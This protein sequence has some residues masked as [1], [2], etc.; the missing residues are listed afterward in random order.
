MS[1]HLNE[2][3]LDA[4]IIAPKLTSLLSIIGSSI[5]ISDVV[6]VY[7]GKRGRQRL[8]P[9]HRLLAG[10]SFCDLLSSPGW[11][12]TSWAVPSDYP[13]SK[14]NVGTQ[15]TC[16]LQGSLLQ[17]AAGTAFYSCSLAIY[18]FLVIRQGWSDKR[19]A[20][21]VE[22]M[23]H[24][25]SL[26]FALGSIIA[27]IALTLY[28]P[29]PYGC[30]MMTSPSGCTQSYQKQDGGVPCERGDNCFIYAF[31]LIHVPIWSIF[32]VLTTCMVL[33][34]IKIKR[35][36]QAVLQYGPRHSHAKA[37]AFQATMYVMAFFITWSGS[38]W[39]SLVY[40]FGDPDRLNWWHIFIGR[41]LLPSQG[42]FNMFVYKLPDYQQYRK[43]KQQEFALRQ[44]HLAS[45][46]NS[47]PN[48]S[49]SSG[50]HE[51]CWILREIFRSSGDC[52][53]GKSPREKDSVQDVQE[54]EQRSVFNDNFNDLQPMEMDD[55]VPEHDHHDQL[56]PNT[57][58]L[59]GEQKQ[60]NHFEN[61]SNTTSIED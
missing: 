29:T 47:R 6:E 60:N 61:D 41:V 3:Q 12:L 31:I 27:C 19:I 16:T 59:P 14:W 32:I 5:I 35:Q 44:L 53:S 23:M 58:S 10:M 28:N 34:Y 26:S 48:H 40:I 24:V 1:L 45:E 38:T 56:Q 25:T 17:C 42:F 52:S 22:P 43:R 4:F 2:A 15:A 36:E 7:R 54:E 30:M 8:S 57:P 9:R 50:R 46:D 49:N 21:F 37:F 51:S 33:I 18:Y 20:K 39:G 55:E 13:Y 11:F